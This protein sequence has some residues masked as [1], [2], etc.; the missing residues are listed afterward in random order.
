MSCLFPSRFEL[1]AAVFIGWGG[2]ILLIS[3]G[4]VL[5]YFS[6]KEGLPKRSTAAQPL[7]SY[8]SR[9]DSHITS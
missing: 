1:G 6:G 2:S 9:F 3:G 4:T 7:H 5:T 8:A